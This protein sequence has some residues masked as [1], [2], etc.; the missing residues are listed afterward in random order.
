MWPVEPL[1][2][3][4]LT[5]VRKPRHQ[6]YHQEPQCRDPKRISPRFA[7]A[8]PIVGLDR[9]KPQDLKDNLHGCLQT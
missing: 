4:P 3:Y 8:M 2:G 1:L 9:N 5:K 6:T 7:L